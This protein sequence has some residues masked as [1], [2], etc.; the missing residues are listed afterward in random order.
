MTEEEIIQR[1]Q[2]GDRESFHSIVDRYKDVLYGTAFLMTN[3]RTAAEDHVQETF[4]AAWRGIGGFHNGHP[5]KPWLVRILVNKVLSY[6]RSVSA[7]KLVT[8]DKDIA[9]NTAV[10]GPAEEVE[11]RD[12][13]EQAMSRITPEQREVIQLRYFTGLSLAE[14]AAVLKRREGTVKSQAHRALE[15]M[16]MVLEAH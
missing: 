15:Q 3:S 16:R 8:I 7:A 1:C 11:K 13:L 9:S 10:D 14:T 2:A 4:I 12:L 5:M 6:R